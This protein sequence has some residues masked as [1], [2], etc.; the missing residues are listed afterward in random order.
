MWNVVLT[1]NYEKKTHPNLQ[2]EKK[3]G[4]IAS[5]GSL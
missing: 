2:L 5:G 1:L 4:N 3:T